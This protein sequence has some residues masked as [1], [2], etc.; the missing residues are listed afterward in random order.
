MKI[1]EQGLIETYEE[2]DD[3]PRTK[4]R[5]NQQKKKTTKI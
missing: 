3:N 2:E 1:Q 4:V 5:Y